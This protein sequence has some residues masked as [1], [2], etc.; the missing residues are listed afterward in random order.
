MS[1]SSAGSR[2]RPDQLD[3]PWTV[4]LNVKLAPWQASLAALLMEMATLCDELVP[5]AGITSVSVCAALD[6]DAT[7]QALWPASAT[8][9][10]AAS[11][12]LRVTA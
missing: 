1:V 6:R 9:S 7:L 12:P 3:A 4:M 8:K 11:A 2:D 5:A 10:V